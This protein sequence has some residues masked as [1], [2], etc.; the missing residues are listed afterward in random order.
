L[1]HPVYIILIFI[2][3]RN[4]KNIFIYISSIGDG[5]AGE[6]GKEGKEE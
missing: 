6:E 2:V 4:N 1:N 5:V 3:T